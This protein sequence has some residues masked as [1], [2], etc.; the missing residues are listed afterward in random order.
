[1]V[2][3]TLKNVKNHENVLGDKVTNVSMDAPI[4][5]AP[6]WTT[7]TAN[8]D[9]L[10]GKIPSALAASF[11][12]AEKLAKAGG[13]AAQFEA[14][15]ATA[16]AELA[17]KG[18]ELLGSA[19]PSNPARYKVGKIDINKKDES[20]VLSNPVG[21]TESWVDIWVTE[22]IKIEHGGTMFLSNGVHARIFMEGKKMEIKDT[23][24][25]KGG[26]IVESGFAGDLQLIGIE[27]SDQSKKESDDEF[28]PRKRSGKLKISDGD[29]TGVINAPDWDVEFKP[30][31]WDKED[32]VN[33][34]QL[35]GSILGRKVK[36]GHGAD[37]HYDEAV[38]EIGSVV[39]YSFA[40]WNEVER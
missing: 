26:F 20:L 27:S 34:A 35:F 8:I 28:S 32:G 11:K 12:I 2:K 39:G 19:D 6:Q 4:N 3:G 15:S 1:M 9:K 10:D 5:L 37:Y 25:D 21:A 16:A 33:G 36:I 23:K 38:S 13:P 31:D 24:A 22:D 40:G 7:V 14:K 17:A 30:K 18:M 29:F